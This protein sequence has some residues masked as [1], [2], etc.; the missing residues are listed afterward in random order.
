MKKKNMPRPMLR[1]WSTSL[2]MANLNLLYCMDLLASQLE[3]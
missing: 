3:L 2:S 1:L